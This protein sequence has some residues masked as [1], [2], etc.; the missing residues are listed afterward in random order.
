MLEAEH[1]SPAKKHIV[2]QVRAVVTA[3]AHVLQRLY[4]KFATRST[5]FAD[6]LTL[7][8]FLL[9]AKQAG[10]LAPGRL[11][12]REAKSAFAQ[13][14]SGVRTGAHGPRDHEKHDVTTLDDGE[15]ACCLCRCAITK[16]LVGNDEPVE[17]EA[18]SIIAQ[19]MQ[20]LA[21]AM[22]LGVFRPQNGIEAKMPPL[23][24]GNSAADAPAGAAT[25]VVVEL[26]PMQEPQPGVPQVEITGAPALAEPGGG[27]STE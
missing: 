5:S 25:N 16:Y 18:A 14:Q 8:D 11:T 23:P 3:H 4:R 19:F 7:P 10:I 22:Q 12:T 20:G 24:S 27:A 26:L 1:V 2:L 6:V 15:F 13:S 9:L 17:S 21:R